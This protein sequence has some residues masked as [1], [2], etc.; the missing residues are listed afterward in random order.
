MEFKCPGQDDRNI[1][2]ETMTC[3]QCGYTLEIFSDEIKVT[4]PRCKT[5]VCKQRLPSCVDWCK[6]AKQCVGT[7]YYQEYVQVKQS[8]LKDKLLAALEV[9]FE[10]DVK[11]IAHAKKVLS[12]AE[13]LLTQEHADWHIV[14]PASILHDV[15]IKAAEAKYGS[16]AGHLQEKE[17]PAIARTIMLGLG[18]QKKDID[19]ICS[20]I[21][22]HHTPGKIDTLNFKV[23]YDA[24]WL[25]NLKD[26]C[27]TSDKQKLDAL[28]E[29]IFL[30]ASGKAL[31][32]KIY[33]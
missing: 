33:L 16:A 15:G 3:S 10:N 13:E 8:T 21:E 5:R 17:G 27:D 22:H 1:Q 2:A 14:I 18:M 29:R 26:E 7:A 20:I 28:I 31:A 30:S 11:R 32:K 25:V 9:Y 6:S 19:E 4:C 12:F 24:D 23:L